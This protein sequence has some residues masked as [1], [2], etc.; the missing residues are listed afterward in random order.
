MSRTEDEKGNVTW[1]NPFESE[2]NWHTNYQRWMATP[3]D[4]HDLLSNLSANLQA[5][6]TAEHVRGCLEE[7]WNQ[8]D[9]VER[10]ENAQRYSDW[11]SSRFKQKWAHACDG[12]DEND[13]CDAGAGANSG[14]CFAEP[15]KDEPR[16]LRC[17]A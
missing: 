8:L 14:L 16:R 12:L 1:D 3:D 7:A 4:L 5:C 15:T 10:N 17:Y 11:L 2:D 6:E 9:V 13:T